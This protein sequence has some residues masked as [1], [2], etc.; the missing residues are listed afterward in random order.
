MK[1]KPIFLGK[2]K[3]KTIRKETTPF[4]N[5]K[6]PKKTYS[7]SYSY[8][9]RYFL[10]LPHSLLGQPLDQQSHWLPQR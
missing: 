8:C 5:G 1:S 9:A 2:G 10:V 3:G 7:Y 4:K 6:G